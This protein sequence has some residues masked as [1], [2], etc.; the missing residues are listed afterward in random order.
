MNVRWSLSSHVLIT[1]VVCCIGTISDAQ[2]VVA[3]DVATDDFKT[4]EF[5]GRSFTLPPPTLNTQQSAKEQ[6]DAMQSLVGK[7][8]WKAFTRDSAVAPVEIDLDYLRDE[9]DQ[10]IGHSVHMAFLVHASFDSLRDQD[11]TSKITGGGAEKDRWTGRL[12]TE[13]EREK[14]NATLSD[15]E[16]LVMFAVPLLDKVELQGVIRVARDESED[17]LTYRFHLDPGFDS[18]SGISPN[19]WK[20]IDADSDEMTVPY[21]G[22]AG[23]LSIQRLSEPAETCFVEARVLMHEPQEWFNGSNFLRSKLPLMMQ[24]IARNFRRRVAK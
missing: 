13:E 14:N 18:P 5:S 23:Y 20:R 24:E 6:L 3:Q 21:K 17:E 19:G 10:R 1:L 8:K 12:L 9:A 2:R 7:A 22:L 4:I 15:D 11:V 16:T